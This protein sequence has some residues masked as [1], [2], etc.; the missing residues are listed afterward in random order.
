MILQPHIIVNFSYNVLLWL[1]DMI[2]DITLKVNYGYEAIYLEVYLKTLHHI[3]IQCNGYEWLHPP[4]K[5]VC[6]V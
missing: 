4:N 6:A 3:I 5:L 2:V 1:I